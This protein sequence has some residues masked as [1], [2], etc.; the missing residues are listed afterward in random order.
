MYGVTINGVHCTEYDLKLTS[1]SNPFP[2][3]K[4][5]AVEIPG[6]D[7]TLDLTEI[8]G[9]P[10]FANRTLTMTFA[11]V[12]GYFTRYPDQSFAAWKMHGKKVPIVLDEDPDF[13]YMGRISFGEWVQTGAAG[14]LTVTAD[15]DPFKYEKIMS[16]KDWLWDPFCFETGV[17]RGYGNLLVNG[18]LAF[19]A[20]GCRMTVVPDFVCSKA[21]QV[22]FKNK[23]YS[24]APGHNT[25]YDIAL[26]D[27]FNRL[28]F[29]GYGTVSIV[30]RGAQL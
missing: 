6:A 30:F 8:Y 25:I 20:F 14:E 29:T 5:A 13:Y 19:D 15:C 27:G 2:A 4:A 9:Q 7:G 21:M 23:T 22:T 24:L 26:E 10:K 3:V 17:A 12:R 11:D 18:S 1:V 16:D 28:V